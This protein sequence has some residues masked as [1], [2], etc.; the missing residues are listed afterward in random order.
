MSDNDVIERL[1]EQN[2]QWVDAKVAEDPSYF[3]EMAKGQHPHTFWIGCADSRVP[4]EQLTDSRPGDLFVH[5][6]V[7][8]LV[9]HTDFNLLAALDYAVEH[10]K[11]QHVV[12]CGHYGCGGV[13]AAMGH[14]D[15]SIINKWIRNVKDVYQDHVKDLRAIGQDD[16]RRDRL[17]ELNVIEQVHNLSKT[18]IIQRAWARGQG[19]ALHGLVYSLEDGRLKDLDVKYANANSLEDIYRFSFE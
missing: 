3:S 19:P 1:L 17:V 5:R 13:A 18:S 2:A 16:R 14:Q 4:P 9:V 8:N 11:V 10:L 7:A 12:V 15:L 6:N